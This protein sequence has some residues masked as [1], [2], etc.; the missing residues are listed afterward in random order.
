VK[1]FG[2]RSY[3]ALDTDGTNLYVFTSDRQFILLASSGAQDI[4]LPI[5]DQLLMLDPTAVYVKV[6]RY[7][8]DSIVRILNTVAQA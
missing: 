1:D 5:A 8:L 7:G 4:G 6:N 2:I 3:N